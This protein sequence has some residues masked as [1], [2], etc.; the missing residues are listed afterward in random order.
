[1]DVLEPFDHGKGYFTFTNLV[2]KLVSA[3]KMLGV[4]ESCTGGMISSLLTSVPGSSDW[5]KGGVVAYSNETKE[6]LLGVNPKTIAKYGAVSEKT[7]QE[8]AA[9]ARLALG[10]ECSLAVTGIAGPGGGTPG[11]EV[12]TV[13][14]AWDIN[15]KVSSE[16]KKFSGTRKDVRLE[17]VRHALDG[18]LDRM[19]SCACSKAAKTMPA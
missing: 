4:A 12:G 18:L 2:V 15:G 10:V 5:F 16:T 6:M 3:G 11:K 8:M 1:M 17:A 9:G 19:G 13:C 14:F 7:A